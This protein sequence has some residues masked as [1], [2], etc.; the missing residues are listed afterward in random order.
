MMALT[1]PVTSLGWVTDLLSHICNEVISVIGGD[2]SV[3][4]TAGVTTCVCHWSA[5]LQE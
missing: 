1:C 4:D 5:I 3:C 2:T